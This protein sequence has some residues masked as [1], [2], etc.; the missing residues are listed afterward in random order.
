MKVSIFIL[1]LLAN[2]VLNDD[3]LSGGSYQRTD[4]GLIGTEIDI[5]LIRRSA[6]GSVSVANRDEHNHLKFTKDQGVDEIPKKRLRE[7]RHNSTRF[8]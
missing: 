5:Y 1:S 8:S 2:V 6:D 4:D 3:L 7:I